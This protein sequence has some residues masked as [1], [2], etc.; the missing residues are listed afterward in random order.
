[1]NIVLLTNILTP[2]RSFFYNQLYREYTRK[3]D[4]FHVV[5]MADTEPGRNWKYDEYKTSYSILLPHK[6]IT[7]F[8]VFIHLNKGLKKLYKSLAPDIVICAGS[9]MYPA[10]WQTL[11]LKKELGFKTYYWNE[12]HKSEMRDYGSIKIRIREF[13]RKAVLGKFDGFWY[14]GQFARQLVDD[15]ASKDATFVFV[16]NLIDIKKFGT[17]KFNDSELEKIRRKYRIPDTKKILFTPARLVKV[18]GIMEFLN[19]YKETE[20]KCKAVYLI[21]GDGE[22][23]QEIEHFAKDNKLD[24]R[25]LGFK[26]ENEVI[27]L[28]AISDIFILPSISDPN[29]LSC[30][31][32]SWCSKPLLLSRH[33]GNYPELIYEGKNGYI[34]SYENKEDAIHKINTIINKDDEWLRKAGEISYNIATKIYNP[35]KAVKRIVTETIV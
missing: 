33:V 10:L 8:G 27:E 5:L 11:A 35:E 12:S 7:L 31:E 21:A 3:G 6:T 29:P 30:I 1:M 9:Y 19:I 16:P 28:Y 23:K 4:D 17:Y 22:L 2:Y 25:L 20:A 18:K 26:S 24:V 34:F 13:I 14:A 15:Y 32:A